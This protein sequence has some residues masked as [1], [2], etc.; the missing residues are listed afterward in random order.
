VE[1]AISECAFHPLIHATI[2]KCWDLP[3]DSSGA[4][5]E[6]TELPVAKSLKYP[7]GVMLWVARAA[8]WSLRNTALH[9]ARNTFDSFLNT[10]IERVSLVFMWEPIA[11][12]ALT[13][14]EFHN[15]LVPSKINGV[16]VHAK[17]KAAP[18]PNQ[19]GNKNGKH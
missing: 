17:I 19:Q 2:D 15:A 10:W 16:S 4:T 5:T 6:V 13:T 12:F 9:A 7:V 18:P 11:H 1:Q 3:S 8:H 14:L